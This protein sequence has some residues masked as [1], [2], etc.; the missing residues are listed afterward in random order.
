MSTAKLSCVLAMGLS[1]SASAYKHKFRMKVCGGDGRGGEFTIFCAPWKKKAS[2][3]GCHHLNKD[4]KKGDTWTKTWTSELDLYGSD[5]SQEENR[6]QD[7]TLIG[8]GDDIC[9]DYIR[10]GTQQDDGKYKL[11]WAT[12]ERFWIS[13]YG[14]KCYGQDTGRGGY[15][16]YQYAHFGACGIKLL[17]DDGSD[18]VDP[19]ECAPSC[20]ATCNDGSTFARPADC[21]DSCPTGY[22]QFGFSR[23]LAS[24]QG[25]RIHDLRDFVM[26]GNDTVDCMDNHDCPT[27]QSCDCSEDD[28]EDNF[29]SA[30]PGGPENRRT[31]MCM[32]A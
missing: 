6:L 22:N 4:W 5:Y 7:M 32:C 9:V 10:V 20:E 19:L 27:G 1:L 13:G 17:R 23:L 30:I 12:N 29:L 25:R 18:V 11:R 3:G 16:C 21:D 24:L 28:Q 15:P 14:G 8:G 31:G 2:N 26:E